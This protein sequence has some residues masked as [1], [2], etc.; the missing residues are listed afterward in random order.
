MSNK[1]KGLNWYNNGI[2]EIF[3]KECP[4]G[5]IPGRINVNLTEESRKKK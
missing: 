1:N 5:F 2:E 4:E 3:C